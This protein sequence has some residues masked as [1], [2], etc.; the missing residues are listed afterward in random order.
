M[1][2]HPDPSAPD[3]DNYDQGADGMP[4]YT[5]RAF[6]SHADQSLGDKP[7]AAIR[8]IERVYQRDPEAV[9]ASSGGK[10]STVT[11]VLASEADVEHRALHWDYG[12]DL[13]PRKY[14]QEILSNILEHVPRDRLL[15]AVEGMARFERYTSDAATPFLEQLATDKRLSDRTPA[16]DEP[17]KPI[18]RAIGPLKRSR[19]EDYFTWQIVA[20]RRGESG[21]RDRSVDGLYGTSLGQPS[22]FP[23]REWSA[24]DVWAF[25]VDRDVTYPRHYDQA[26]RTTGDGSPT[27]YEAARMSAWFFEFLD[28]YTQHGLSAWRHGDIP[29]REWDR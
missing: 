24:R 22:A 17:D 9:V 29:A 13:V 8:E 27:D 14:E 3:P 15:V 7:E 4:E 21:K 11:L 26:A 2:D 1:V 18:L 19:E 23:L 28:P 5:R 25:L 12:P 6:Q 20:L 16:T 10:D